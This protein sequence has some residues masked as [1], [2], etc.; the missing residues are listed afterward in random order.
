ME[1]SGGIVVDDHTFMRQAVRECLAELGIEPVRE[2][3]SLSDGR[4]L[5]AEFTP[6]IAV[7]DL[8]LDDGSSLELVSTLK[9]AGSRVMVLSS[10]DDGYSVR[11]AY[12][13]GALGYLMKSAPSETVMHGLREVLAGRIYADPSVAMLLVQGVQVETP[14]EATALTEREIAVLRLVAAG[15]SNAEIG[16]ELDIPALSVKSHLNRIGR[17]LGTGD[18]TEMVAAAMRADVL[19]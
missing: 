18:R 14:P 13:A 11:S 19:R 2:A 15:R 5:V 12:A 7:L 16:E 8:R 10:A 1:P 17:K 6:R 4:V 9:N 3:S